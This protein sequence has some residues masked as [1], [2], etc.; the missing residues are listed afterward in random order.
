MD[1]GTGFRKNNEK[2]KFI[3]NYKEQGFLDHLLMRIRG[4]SLTKSQ[5]LFYTHSNLYI[6]LLVIGCDSKEINTI[7]SNT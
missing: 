1:G 4:I 7:K 2:I 5:Y 3:N 6:F